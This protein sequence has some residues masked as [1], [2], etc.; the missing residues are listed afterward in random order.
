MTLRARLLASAVAAAMSVLA[1]MVMISVFDEFSQVPSVL[2][3]VISVAFV[4]VVGWRFLR[5]AV[6]AT[7][8]GLVLRN[9]LKDVRISWQHVT[10]I[11]VEE[12]A[13]VLGRTAVSCI[14]TTS[15]DREIVWL[16]IRLERRTCASVARPTRCAITGIV[17][18]ET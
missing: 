6:V 3:W 12:G 16:A 4:G 7:D 14:Q 18:V 15:G 13:A 10:D 5:V 8:Q 9:V 17:V 2:Q 1:A 11:R